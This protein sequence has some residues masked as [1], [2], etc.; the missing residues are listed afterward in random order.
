MIVE[1]MDQFDWTDPANIRALRAHLRD[2]AK[3]FAERCGVSRFQTVFEWES[4][5]G[6][7]SGTAQKL[8]DCIANAEGFTPGIARKIIVKMNAEK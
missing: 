3:R 7:P 2:T 1:H 8:F 6:V 4:G 5:A